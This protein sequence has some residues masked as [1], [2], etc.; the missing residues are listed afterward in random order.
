MAADKSARGGAGRGQGR[1][2]I[3]GE[4]MKTYTFRATEAQHVEFLRRGGSKWL[5]DKIEEPEG[6]VDRLRAALDALEG[7]A[8]E[9][10][11]K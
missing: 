1:K 9:G 6:E 11:E 10:S 5:R 7:K 8:D 4:P 2:P 3:H